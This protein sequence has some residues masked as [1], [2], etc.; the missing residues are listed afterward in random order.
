[1]PQYVVNSF[2]LLIVICYCRNPFLTVLSSSSFIAV[3]GGSV[4]VF[5]NSVAHFDASS[6]QWMGD[7]VAEMNTLSI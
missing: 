2:L 5:H 7:M 6:R 3:L 1:M 4:C